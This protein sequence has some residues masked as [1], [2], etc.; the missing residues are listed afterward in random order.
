LITPKTTRMTARIQ[1]RK[2]MREKFPRRRGRNY[3]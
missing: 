2:A 3:C 1:S